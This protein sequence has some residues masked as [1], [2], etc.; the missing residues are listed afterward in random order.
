MFCAHTTEVSYKPYGTDGWYECNFA[1]VIPSCLYDP[2]K[3]QLSVDPTYSLIFGI[4]SASLLKENNISSY[5]PTKIRGT[6]Y[7]KQLAPQISI[8]VGSIFIDTPEGA[9]VRERTLQKMRIAYK[10]DNPVFQP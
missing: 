3:Y 9:Q 1:G 10:I 7:L 4:P 5:N 6:L 8:Y 2:K